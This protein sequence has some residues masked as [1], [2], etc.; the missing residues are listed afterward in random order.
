MVKLRAEL[1]VVYDTKE[2]RKFSV[3]ELYMQLKLTGLFVA[4]PE[5][6]KLCSLILSIPITSAS[7]ER[8]FSALKRIKSYACSTQKEQRL[9]GLSL[10]SIEKNLLRKLRAKSDFYDKVITEFLKKDRRMDFIYK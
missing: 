8:S 2:L 4:L 6:T 10:L 7:P 1:I 3:Y 5:V 9:T